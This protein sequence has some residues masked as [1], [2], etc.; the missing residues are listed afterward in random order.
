MSFGPKNPLRASRK[1]ARPS[2]RPWV[3]CLEART[4][5]SVTR[6]VV[7]DH[8]SGGGSLR[9]VLAASGNGDTIKFDKSLKNHVIKLTSDE[10]T[11]TANVSI[12]G[13]GADKLTVS[14]GDASRVFTIASGTS[15]KIDGLTVA[16]GK[17]E[18]GGGIDNFGTLTL[19]NSV[20]TDNQAVGGLGGGGI[21]NE[22]GATLTLDHDAVTGNTAHVDATGDVLG[23]GLLNQDTATVTASSFSGNQAT[24][25]A[26]FDALGGSAGGAIDNYSQATLTVSDSTFSDNHAVAAAG[27]FFGMGGAIDNNAG[28]DG[29]GGSTATITNSSF[30]GNSAEG[31]DGG[32]FGQGGAVI[33]QSGAS[34]MTLTGCTLTGNRAVGGSGATGEGASLGQ[35]QGGAVVNGVATMTITG[36][37]II[38]NEADGGDGGTPT[39][40]NPHT[41]GGLGGGIENIA[42]ATLTITDSLV[43]G[44]VARGGDTTA[45]PGSNALGGGID[46]TQSSSLTMKNTKVVGNQAVAGHGGPG[47]STVPAGIASGG[48]LNTQFGNAFG[49]TTPTTAT[50]TDSVFSGNSALGSDGGTGNAGGGG[51]GGGIAVGINA[52]VGVTRPDF[53]E[54][55]VLTLTNTTVDHNEAQGGRGGKGADGGAGLGGGL[56]LYSRSATTPEVS[57]QLTN[58]TVDHNRADGGQKGQGGADGQGIGGGVYDFQGAFALDSGSAVKKNHASFSDDDLFTAP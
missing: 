37:S 41:G 31:R 16:H 28:A 57:A 14:G 46:N 30:T 10:L 4:V 9:A 20:L 50:I 7:N 38:G 11:V 32:G 42:F 23:G 36:C 39:S 13:L 21:D 6:T 56:W 12:L 8:D 15:V 43:S 45:G 18:V 35:G 27:T 19:S 55:S 1:P 29:S 51:F 2:A 44:N 47:T 5:P 49:G 48:G 40:D 22:P 26:A 34:T 54:N 52:F 58:S 33:N 53:P 24:G 25:G 17:A 3:E